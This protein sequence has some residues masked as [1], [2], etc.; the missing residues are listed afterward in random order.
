MERELR[1]RVTGGVDSLARVVNTLRRS[2][3]RLLEI[4]SSFDGNGSASV[5]VRL[6]GDE[7]E[8]DWVVK[9]IFVLVD[10]EDVEVV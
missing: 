1:I 10:V 4:R 7:A 6:S 2:R 3:A 5:S 9:K 8:I